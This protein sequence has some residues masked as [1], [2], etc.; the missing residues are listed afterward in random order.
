MVKLTP[1][2]S[3]KFL[4]DPKKVRSVLI[5]G[6]NQ[7]LISQSS[8][9]ISKNISGTDSNEFSKIIFDS[10]LILTNPSDL[11]GSISQGSLLSD[12]SRVIIL[13]N[14]EDTIVNVIKSFLDMPVRIDDAYLILESSDLGPRSKLRSLFEKEQSLASLPCYHDDANT[15]KNTIKLY[16]EEF[17]LE[18]TPEAK[19][20]LINHLGKDS[21][22]TKT[23]IE[24]LS[25]YVNDKKVNLELAI[26]CLGDNSLVTQDFLIDSIG[27]KNIENSFRALERLT[28]EGVSN[29]AII[30]ILI[31]HFNNLHSIVSS[32]DRSQA[33]LS[34]WPPIH[35][36]RKEAFNKQLQIWSL[37]SL[38]VVLETLSSAEI[39]SK[40]SRI[41]SEI[42]LK[43]AVLKVL[44]TK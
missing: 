30:R 4:Q 41:K 25:I 37:K 15:L 32:N 13:Q 38:S 16:T 27:L 9:K 1:S 20:Y 12:S 24:K 26:K 6:P 5:Y 10:S 33:I 22:I 36:K 19:D 23:E 31:R 35:F 11:L 8:S 44:L 7:G 18:L 17:D 21:E 43:Q 2:L 3:N 14:C 34:L 39:M 28:T 42:I 29:I 40:L